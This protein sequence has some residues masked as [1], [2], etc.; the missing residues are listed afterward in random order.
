MLLC[1][2]G[3]RGVSLPVAVVAEAEGC[4][5]VTS[6]FVEKLLWF[7]FGFHPLFPFMLIPYM[8]FDSTN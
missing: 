6:G 2:A 4:G 1:I 5:A 7:H 3:G 8:P